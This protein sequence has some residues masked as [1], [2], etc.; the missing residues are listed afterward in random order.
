MKQNIDRYA[1]A[2]LRFQKSKSC[3]YSFFLNMLSINLNNDNYEV[4]YRKEF[5]RFMCEVIEGPYNEVKHRILECVIKT[6]NLIS[7][8]SYPKLVR[9]IFENLL[10]DTAGDSPEF[11][12][13]LFAIA[14]MLRPI[15][16][17]EYELKQRLFKSKV[18]KE[19][20]D[21]ND[22][23]KFSEFYDAAQTRLGL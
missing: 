12:Y 15:C 1:K 23:K 11:L 10:R 7:F 16:Q 19:K 5:L 22:I 21:C 20:S 13:P 4:I 9:V 14:N 8:K 17:N 2:V 6:A 3:A 18:I